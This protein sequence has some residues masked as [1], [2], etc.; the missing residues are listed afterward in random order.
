MRSLLAWSV[1]RDGLP[2]DRVD[3]SHSRHCAGPTS[4]QARPGEA[5]QDHLSPTFAGGLHTENLL[6]SNKGKDRIARQVGVVLG[7]MCRKDATRTLLL[8]IQSACINVVEIHHKDGTDA[9]AADLL[10]LDP[11]D[12]VLVE[13][14]A[15]IVERTLRIR[16]GSWPEMFTTLAASPWASNEGTPQERQAEFERILASFRERT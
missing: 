15:R 2:R 12:A 6:A 13:Q 16:P 3:R 14:D 4:G 9:I 10:P 7:L 5:R 1:V 8:D 11:Q